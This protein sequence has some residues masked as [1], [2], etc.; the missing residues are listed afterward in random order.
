MSKV[1]GNCRYFVTVKT[2]SEEHGD[3]KVIEKGYLYL[4]NKFDIWVGFGNWASWAD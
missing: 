1:S 3:V 2:K 4:R